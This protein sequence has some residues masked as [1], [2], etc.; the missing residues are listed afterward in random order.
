VSDEAEPG[1]ASTAD[2]GEIKGVGI[3]SQER[4]PAKA[5][6]RQ[7]EIA[8]IALPTCCAQ[9]AIAALRLQW[10]SCSLAVEFSCRLQVPLHEIV[11][12]MCRNLAALR[13]ES[14]IR[15]LEITWK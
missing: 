8:G 12:S 14:P 3:E 13:E 4:I 11:A 6:S 2:P 9:S 1:S 10:L 15:S 7:I 5:D